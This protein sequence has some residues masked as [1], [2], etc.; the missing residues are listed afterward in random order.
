M[1][2][3]AHLCPH[4]KEKKPDTSVRGTC[5]A[6]GHIA[7]ANLPRNH[8]P[9]TESPNFTLCDACGDHFGFCVWCWGPINGHGRITVPTDK[10]FVRAFEKENGLHIEGMNVGE[11]VLA[12]F[13][14]DRFT[15]LIWE[16]KD[17][18]CGVRLVATRM[19]QDGAAADDRWWWYGS[20]YAWLEFYFELD[21]SN[22]A[23]HI[24]MVQ[25]SKY[26]WRPI[27]KPKIWRVTV[28]VRQ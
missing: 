23:A 17:L 18:S 19:V 14:I 2:A 21:R 9:W 20:R 7:Q 28:E 3:L 12:Q 8:V 13:A 26:E 27:T 4:C 5:Q 10:T 11:Q 16:V 22:P 25:A 1:K 6:A 15:G 24:E